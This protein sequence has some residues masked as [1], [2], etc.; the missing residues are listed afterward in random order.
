MKRESLKKLA[1]MCL[2]QSELAL[3]CN[4]LW[5]LGPEQKEVHGGPVLLMG[6]EERT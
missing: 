3:H 5:T 1:Y 2:V 6:Q 4:Q